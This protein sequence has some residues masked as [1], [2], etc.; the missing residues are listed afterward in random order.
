MTVALWQHGSIEWLCDSIKL[1]L[2]WMGYA[3]QHICFGGGF[4][5]EGQQA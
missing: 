2:Q 4:G 5:M 1:V 3:L